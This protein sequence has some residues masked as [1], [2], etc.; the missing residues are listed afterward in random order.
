[1]SV[2]AGKRTC[3]RQD[4]TGAR[5]LLGDEQIL[6]KLLKVCLGHADAVICFPLV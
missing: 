6:A 5:P 1:M 4:G 3:P 2:I